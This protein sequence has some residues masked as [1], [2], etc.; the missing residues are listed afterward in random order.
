MFV[1]S[2]SRCSFSTLRYDKLKEH[3]HKQHKVGSAPERRLRITDLVN[4]HLAKTI[5]CSVSHPVHQSL[6][7]HST[8]TSD[9]AA[10]LRQSVPCSADL[11][12][13][14]EMAHSVKQP[15]FVESSVV[16]VEPA[17]FLLGNVQ[18]LLTRTPPLFQVELEKDGLE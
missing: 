2:C 11:N 9:T 17:D 1:Y 5:E 12:T 13:S 4:L 6:H 14:T 18:P 15:T 10:P 7:Q 8:D 3:L 16:I